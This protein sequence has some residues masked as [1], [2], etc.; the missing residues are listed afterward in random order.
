MTN[1]LKGNTPSAIY[2]QWLSVGESGDHAG[3]TATLK[4]VW[5]D[6]GAGSKNDSPFKLSTG[7]LRLETSNQLRFRDDA[8]YIYSSAD[9]V[10]NLIAD[11]E[12]DL[13][14]ATIDINATTSCEIDNT[15]LTNGVKLGSNVSGMPITI[16]HATSETTVADNLTVTGTTAHSDAVTMAS[17]KKLQ[18]VDGNEY[19]SGNSA[20]L[21]LG[22]SSDINLTAT[23]DVNIPANI[24]LTFGNDGEKIEGDGTDLTAVSS[25]AF[26]I[27][28]GG[29]STWS[30]SSGALTIDAAAAALNLDGSSGV[31]IIGNA[32]EIDLTTTGLVDINSANFKLDASGTMSIDVTGGASNI[33][34]TTDASAEDFTIAVAGATDSS[35]ILSSTGTGADAIQIS[36]S[37]GGVDISGSSGGDIDITSTGKSVNITSTEDVVDSIVISSTNGGIDIIAAGATAGEDID[38][39]ASGSSVNITSTENA[40]KAVYLHAN[41]GVSESIEIRSDQG[42]AAKSIYISSNNGGIVIDGDTDHGVSIGAAISGSPIAIGHETSET[43]IGDNLTVSGDLTVNGTQSYTALSIS[44]A[45]ATVF[46]LDNQEHS[47]ADGARDITFKFTGENGSGTSVDD[48][49]QIVIAH[50]GSSADEKGYI[51]LKTNSGSEGTSPS[52]ALKLSADNT[53]TF[54]GAIAAGTNTITGGQLNIDNIRV[55]GNTVSATNS[56]GDVIIAPSGTGGIAVL[57]TDVAGSYAISMGN[58][59]T[60]DGDYGVAIGK[61]AR[62][63]GNRSV[64]IGDTNTASGVNSVAIGDGNTVSASNAI[65]IGYNGKADR[66]AE[67][68]FAGG[69]MSSAG[70]TRVSMFHNAELLTMSTSWQNIDVLA[71]DAI[72]FDS[73]SVAMGSCMFVGSTSGAAVSVG[74]KIDF[75]AENDGGVY[76][77]IQQSKTSL[78]TQGTSLD[79]QIAISS[80]VLVAQV[81]DS[82]GTA[83]MQWSVFFQFVQH[84]Y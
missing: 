84:T 26:T 16:G 19:L 48:M 34:S 45:T 66:L 33:T 39:T 15:N 25:G 36:A 40:S 70:D 8:I 58:G 54:S 29:A 38:I 24:G 13:A 60:A 65:A 46:T 51:D 81:T 42:T 12:I 68:S 72:T 2:K 64:A 4:S 56:N 11:G 5:T 63:T 69:M 71:K 23:A 32:A 79:A 37:A 9:T 22:A 76:S 43:T 73:D 61:S 83:T 10:L 30:L 18:F 1:F 31:N 21:T 41:G 28:G 62:A 82:A 52:S 74:F 53:A 27:T 47:N 35:L 80:N 55:D 78:D 7:A 44:H 77:V 59:A 20:D 6:D 14:T 49:A 3:L 75:V 17:G 50:D 67:F 57:N